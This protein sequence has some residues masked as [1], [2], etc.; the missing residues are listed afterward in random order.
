MLL[1]RGLRMIAE[2]DLEVFL[3]AAEFE[4]LASRTERV[5]NRFA[6]RRV[7]ASRQP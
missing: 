3:R 1:D 2:G 5:A 7:A 6:A 4:P